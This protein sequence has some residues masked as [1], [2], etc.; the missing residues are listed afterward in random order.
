MRFLP[1]RT[2]FH[3]VVVGSSIAGFFHPLIAAEEQPAAGAQVSAST[4]AQRARQEFKQA[5]TAYQSATNRFEAG[6][7]LARAAFDL[8]EFATGSDERESLAETGIRVSRQLIAENPDSVQAH[9][10]LGMNLGQLA[11]TKLL[12]ALKLVDQMEAEFTMARALDAKFD[13]AGADRNLG[14]L[15]LEAPSFGSIGSRKNARTHLQRAVELAPDYPEN[16][17]NLIEAYLRW[18]ERDAALKQFRELEALLPKARESFSGDQWEA[19][20]TDWNKRLQQ[21]RAKLASAKK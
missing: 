9:Y 3:A 20:W 13:Y 6:W 7:R 10:Y 11:R 21:T 18:G 5:Q 12:G 8:A 15:Y 16:R 17:L 2:W 19:S 1:M 4:P 14:L